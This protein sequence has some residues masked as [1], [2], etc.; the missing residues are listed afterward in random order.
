MFR[1]SSKNQW[2]YYGKLDNVRTSGN[3][4]QWVLFFLEA[5]QH[6][7]ADAVENIQFLRDLQQKNIELIQSRIKNNDNTMRLFN[8][9]TESPII[10][11][12][13][14]ME[15]LDVSRGTAQKCVDGLVELG[16]LHETTKQ[17]RNRIFAYGNYL[18][19]LRKD[20]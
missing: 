13:S 15:A 4:E 10:S 12:K 16:I 11:I 6:A 9:I 7:A 1:T 5:V 8:Y 20:T 14:T 18:A 17:A 3:Y 2:E 19:I